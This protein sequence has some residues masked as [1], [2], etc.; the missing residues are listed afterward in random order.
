MTDQNQN[1]E[2]KIRESFDAGGPQKAP[3]GLWSSL[4]Q[5]LDQSTLD[6]RVKQSFHETE[7]PAPEAVWQNVNQQLNIDRSWKAIYQRL[8]W[9]TAAIWG[10]RSALLLIP[11]LLIWFAY[12][13]EDSIS[14]SNEARPFNKKEQLLPLSE[15]GVSSKKSKPEASP[16]KGGPKSPLSSNQKALLP[17]GTPSSSK[18]ISK[19]EEKGPKIFSDSSKEVPTTFIGREDQPLKLRTWRF[20]EPQTSGLA[21]IYSSLSPITS[22][23]QDKKPLEFQAYWQL[24]LR[25][26]YDRFLVDNNIA[27]QASDANSLVAG[28]RDAGINYSVFLTYNWSEKSRLELSFLWDETLSQ[29]YNRFGEGLYLNEEM[30]YRFQNYSINY[31]YRWV[32]S[33]SVNAPAILIGVGP[34]YAQLKSVKLQSDLGSKGRSAR[35]RDRYGF[36]FKI[37]QEFKAGDISLSY[38]IQGQFGLNNFHQGDA[39]LPGEFDISRSQRIGF[40]LGTA[41]NF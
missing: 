38:G 37:G 27:R 9:R 2:G 11:L 14:E 30:T 25:I 17:S 4:E 7:S 24:G 22:F 33:E 15:K 12:P 34:Y 6:A 23:A 40:Y 35:Y 8:N 28:Q 13:K 5:K 26:H 31:S 21:P 20:L 32:L 3:Q 41:Y 18:S 16:S 39:N 10:M 19:L 29:S 1:M 36:I